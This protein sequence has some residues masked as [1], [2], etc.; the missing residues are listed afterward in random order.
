MNNL[1]FIHISNNE[2]PIHAKIGVNPRRIM[3]GK[4]VRH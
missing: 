2:L 3:L 1:L 4:E